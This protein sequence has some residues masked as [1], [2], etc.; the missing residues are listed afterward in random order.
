MEPSVIITKIKMYSLVKVD[1]CYLYLTGRSNEKLI[2]ANAMEMKLPYDL[3]MYIKE[4]YKIN[5][6]EEYNGEVISKEQNINLYDIL[7]EKH[8]V[9]SFSKRPNPVGE[10]LENARDMFINLSMERQVY[11]IQQILQ[12]S[13]L[14][15]MGADLT[16][17]GQSKKTGVMGI[18]KK[19]NDR[20]EII[21]INQS[22]TGLFEK[23]IDP[24]K[25]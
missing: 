17:I 14:S 1:G 21:L 5:L 22:P 7:T 25:V 13:K 11:V 9:S 3:I 2:V 16:D 24:L 15:N 20:N 23:E 18:N 19:I 4:L 8:I 10:K 6:N 12:L